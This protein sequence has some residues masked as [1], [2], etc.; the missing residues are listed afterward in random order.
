MTTDKEDKMLPQPSMLG[1]D[2]ID[3]VFQSL[4]HQ[5]PATRRYRGLWWAMLAMMLFGSGYIA[6]QTYQVFTHHIQVKR[7]APRGP[8]NPGDPGTG[9]GKDRPK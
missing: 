7:E 2:H 9:N 4:A 8:D 6:L 5:R 1:M 3:A